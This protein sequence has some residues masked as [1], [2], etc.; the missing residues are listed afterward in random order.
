M[1]LKTRARPIWCLD[2]EEAKS[3]HENIKVM[4]I[5]ME[6]CQTEGLVITLASVKNKDMATVLADVQ[7][8]I[9][10]QKKHKQHWADK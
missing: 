5:K 6:A 8:E 10:K 9:D 3:L 2:E 4:R 7:I 1:E